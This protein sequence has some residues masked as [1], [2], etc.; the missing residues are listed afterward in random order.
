M[1]VRHR[2]RPGT[3]YHRAKSNRRRPHVG[4]VRLFFP[5]LSG[6]AV[7][8]EGLG[9]YCATVLFTFSFGTSTV[10]SGVRIVRLAPRLRITPRYTFPV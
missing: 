9:P 2:G 8:A 1:H 7:R 10:P 6:G 4:A 3:F 5:E